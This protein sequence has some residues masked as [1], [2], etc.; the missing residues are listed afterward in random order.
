MEHMLAVV[1]DT[2]AIHRDPWLAS[3]TAKKLL[4]WAEVDACVIVYPQ[5]VADE[6]R[7]QRVEAARAAHELAAKGI[8]DMAVAGIDVS[9]TVAE[10]ASNLV[11]I[12]SD[13]DA[14]FAKVL[15]HKNVIATPVPNV[16]T[17]DLLSRDLER[18]RPFMEIEHGQKKKSVGF[19][20]VLIWET[21]LEVLVNNPSYSPVLLVTS[22]NGFLT[23]DSPRLHPDLIADLVSRGI[24]LR[25]AATVKSIA[26]AIAELEAAVEKVAATAPDRADPGDVENPVDI[27]VDELRG[28]EVRR[29]ELVTAA[30][31]ALYALES[32]DLS[33]QM[34]YGGD[35][36]YPEFVKFTMPTLE[37]GQITSI[38]QT[39]EFSFEESSISPDILIARTDAV[40][41][42]EGAVYKGDWFG[43][44]SDSV[45]I[46][47]ELN[48]H[49]LEA[50]SE[51]EVRVVIELDVEGGNVTVIDLAL[52]DPPAQEADML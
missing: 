18:R 43:D 19:R 39:T 11:R 51:V 30:T 8:E 31:E 48:D 17:R 16:S 46:V 33:M 25:R 6:L 28:S 42:I 32:K 26:Q 49:Y 37:S 34:V 47:G 20:D 7:R 44:D 14:A 29:A 45:D 35:Y 1:L 40:I 4:R 23:K 10:L 50:S 52:E 22:D 2:N 12:E 15:L 9:L 21:M 13:I 41:T 27:A 3:D 24:V 5:V 38:D 36:D